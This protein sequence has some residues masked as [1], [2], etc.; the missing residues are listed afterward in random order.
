MFFLNSAFRS[1]IN[2]SSGNSHQ[3]TGCTKRS[4]YFITKLFLVPIPEAFRP[5]WSNK[6]KAIN[7]FR[8]QCVVVHRSSRSSSSIRK[9]E[10]E[11]MKQ[12]KSGVLMKEGKKKASDKTLTTTR[13]TNHW[14]LLLH[15]IKGSRTC[16]KLF[17]IDRR[18]SLQ[19]LTENRK[20]INFSAFVVLRRCTNTE[21]TQRSK[22]S[23]NTR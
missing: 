14:F 15:I 18:N 22:A 7:F 2:S 23:R 16:A 5:E 10:A 3:S 19:N 12:Q 6:K 13:A 4:S 21:T 17:Y 8:Y 11:S 9:K 1:K 20:Y